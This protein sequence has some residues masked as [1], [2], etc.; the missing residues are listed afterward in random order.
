[1]NVRSIALLAGVLTVMFPVAAKA[2][3]WVTLGNLESKTLQFSLRCAGATAWHNFS[4]GAGRYKQFGAGDWNAEDCS[5]Y[6]LSIGTNQGNGTA[7]TQVAR[8]TNEHTYLLVKTSSVGYAVH[9]AQQ[10]IVV[11][12]AS[13][14]DL[15]L[16][17]FCANVGSKVMSIGPHAQSWLFVGN[18]SACN[19]YV[20]S[21]REAGREMATLPTTSLPTGNVYTLT[22]N[23]DKH[24]WN[25]RSTHAGGGV[26]DPGN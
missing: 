23:D 10:M 19:P 24:M 21:V 11:M 4:L 14:R 25:I 12:N 7:S 16:N 6:E 8:M 3:T 18:P 17:Y 2:D 22:W 5:T 13:S 26:G 20:G 9:D 15:D 1:M